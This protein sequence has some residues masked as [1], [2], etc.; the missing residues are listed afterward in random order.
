MVTYRWL[1]SSQAAPA[2]SWPHHVIQAQPCASYCQQRPPHP[3][4][5]Q[6][7]RDPRPVSSA[8]RRCGWPNRRGWECLWSRHRRCPCSGDQVE[9]S[10]GRGT[11]ASPQGNCASRQNHGRIQRGSTPP[12]A[13]GGVAAGVERETP[14][15]G[16]GGLHGSS[17][18]TE[19]DDVRIQDSP[20]SLLLLMAT[21]L[22]WDGQ[23]G[24]G[25][26]EKDRRARGG[27]TGDQESTLGWPMTIHN[28]S[29]DRLD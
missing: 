6:H 13:A 12:T 11:A 1:A 15:E 3:S 18:R 20:L 21:P 16:R 17:A 26:S 2:S 19:G 23:W 7:R 22:S 24:E 29:S 27:R 8:L 28:Q 5:K 9:S 10:H 4:S 14:G 25:P